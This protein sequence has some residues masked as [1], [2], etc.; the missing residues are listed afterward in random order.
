VHLGAFAGWQS[1]LESRPVNATRGS[2]TRVFANLSVAPRGIRVRRGR[3]VK[4]RTKGD[5]IEEGISHEKGG[6]DG[7]R[8][9]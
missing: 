2:Q 5:I 4:F 7:E 8:K 3:A 9:C 6:R 1:A